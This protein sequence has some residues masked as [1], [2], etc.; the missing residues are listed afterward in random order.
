[1]TNKE[2][3]LN[4]VENLNDTGL[5]MLASLFGD[6]SSNER[7]NKSTTAERLEE[8]KLEALKKE[9]ERKDKRDYESL[10]RAKEAHRKEEE[11]LENLPMR[12]KRLFRKLDEVSLEAGRYSMDL[13][14]LL[15]FR[16]VYENNLLNGSYHIYLYGFMKGVIC[17]RR[18]YNDCT[19]LEEQTKEILT[20]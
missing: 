3:L 8:I 6:F 9:A 12:Y 18:K 10:E 11:K 19:S 20:A 15:I 13:D 2:I 5:S 14:E 4:M 16:D 7:Y 17:E 1:M